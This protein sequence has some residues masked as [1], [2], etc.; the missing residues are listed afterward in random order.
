MWRTNVCD[1]ANVHILKERSV[2]SLKLKSLEDIFLSSYYS[3]C[4]YD[5]VFFISSNIKKF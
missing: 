4:S 3:M 2:F 1:E 5:F